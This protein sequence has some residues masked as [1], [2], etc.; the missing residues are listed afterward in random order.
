MACSPITTSQTLPVGRA[1]GAGDRRAASQAGVTMLE[2]MVGLTLV[3]I[4]L[5]GMNGLWVV[6]G[7]Q[8]DDVT[9]RQKAILRLNGE[10][11]RLARL[12]V[13]GVGPSQTIAV[14]DYQSNGPVQ[15]G[16]Y[17]ATI[18]NTVDGQR[19][20]YGSTVLTPPVTTDPAVFAVTVDVDKRSGDAARYPNAVYTRIYYY[21]NGTGGAATTDDRNFVWLDRERNVVAQIS[22]ELMKL[23]GSDGTDRPC[24]ATSGTNG[25][26][27]LTLY[28]DYPFRYS[29]GSPRGDMGPV[30]TITLQTI[31]GERP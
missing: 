25:C 26:Q 16:S 18:A 2:V 3:A 4:L 6:V 23:K 5:V 22:W 28:L 20:I 17:I 14:T 27:L 21:D 30:E 11:E 7:R 12:Y 13:T 24:Y 19:L 29:D 15:R 9:L 1:G 10:M 31:V 8:L